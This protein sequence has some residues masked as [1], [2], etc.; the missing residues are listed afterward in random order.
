MEDGVAFEK[1]SRLRVDEVRKRTARE[2]RGAVGDRL[3]VE[4]VDGSGAFGIEDRGI[5]H[6]IHGRAE[7]GDVERNRVLSRERRMDVNNT[8]IR[9]K[10]FAADLET[11]TAEGKIVNGDFSGGVG[12]E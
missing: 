5:G 9:G 3:R 2:G 4:V 7:G 11:I 1:P 10:R 8:V 6:D 12:G